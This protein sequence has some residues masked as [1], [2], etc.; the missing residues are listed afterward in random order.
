M[1]S[2]GDASGGVP[3]APRSADEPEHEISWLRAV[4]SGVAVLVVGI[5]AAVVGAN[6]ILTKALAVTRGGRE[7]LATALFLVVLVALSWALR[8]MQGRGWI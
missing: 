1:S 2:V 4:L 8:W 6:R 5:G 7:A 3:A